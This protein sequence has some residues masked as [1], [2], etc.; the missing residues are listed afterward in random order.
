MADDADMQRANELTLEII[1]NLRIE[2]RKTRRDL[3]YYKDAYESARE[4]LQL[5][6]EIWDSVVTVVEQLIRILR[7]GQLA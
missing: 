2:L 7:H 4:G 6:K 3:R 5:Q 1:E